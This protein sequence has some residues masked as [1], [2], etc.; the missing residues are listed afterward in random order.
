MRKCL[1][2]L[3]VALLLVHCGSSGKKEPK[4][5]NLLSRSEFKEALELWHFAIA[6]V[7]LRMI[8]GE[9]INDFP[10]LQAHVLQEM[11]VD[12]AKFRQTVDWYSNRPELLMEVYQEILDEQP[13]ILP[14]D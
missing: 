1:H 13:A 5:S 6:A 3:F 2:I 10:A 7:E 14:E 9:I 11:G 12:T 4:S 8:K